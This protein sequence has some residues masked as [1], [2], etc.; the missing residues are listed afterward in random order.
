MEI[1]R[2]IVLIFCLGFIFLGCSQKEKTKVAHK[3]TNIFD[4]NQYIFPEAKDITAENFV[5]K[6]FACIKHYHKEP[7][8][9]FRINK[10][11]CLIEVY[12]N[13]INNYGDFELSNTITPTKIGHILKSG[14][15]EIK[16]KMYPVGNLINED[17]GKENAPP[18]ITL[19]NNA[20][21]EIEVIMMDNKSKKGLDSERSIKKIVSTKEAAGKEYYEFSFTFD[22]EVPYEFEGWNKGQNLQNLDQ[23]LVQK[24]AIEFYQMVGE[25]YV[26]NDLNAI[27]KL[28]YP[29]TYRIKQVFFRNKNSIN[30]I[31]KE[32]EEDINEKYEPAPI[33]NFKLDYMGNGKLLSLLTNNKD[34]NLIGGG[35]LILNFENGVFQPG[36][37]LYLPEGRDLAT[38]GFMMW[39]KK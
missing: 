1:K 34:A 4:I 36:I 8:Y 3:I 9:Y 32:Y 20:E 29:F 11:N 15:Q 33:N 30:G 23:D 12:I 28:E 10:Q 21:V 17:L 18:A 13:D 7:I 24:K 14:K 35:A 38:Q 6:V 5:E 19:S 26:N 27:L 37:T 16:V 2:K 39:K 22:A 25:I 31:L